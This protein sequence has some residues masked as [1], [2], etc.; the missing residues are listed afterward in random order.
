M[1]MYE[2]QLFLYQKLHELNKLERKIQLVQDKINLIPND[3]WINTR[4][5]INLFFQK[6]EF[7]K[8]LEKLQ[9]SLRDM[10]LNRNKH[11]INIKTIK[12]KE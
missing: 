3:N 12:M 8:E 4:Y 1:K 9:C 2:R 11:I 7:L 5:R 10:V 6:I